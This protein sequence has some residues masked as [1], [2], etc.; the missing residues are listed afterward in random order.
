MKGEGGN[1]QEFSLFLGSSGNSMPVN[2]DAYTDIS[3]PESS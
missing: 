2:I 1:A 3:K